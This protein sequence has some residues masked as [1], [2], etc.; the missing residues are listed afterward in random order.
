MRISLKN[1]A[2]VFANLEAYFLKYNQFY[3][4]KYV[5]IP[6]PGDV[7]NFIADSD[8]NGIPDTTSEVSLEGIR[9]GYTYVVVNDVLYHYY[10]DEN[11]KIKDVN[12][13]VRI[14]NELDNYIYNGMTK[15]YEE[16]TLEL[17]NTP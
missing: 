12:W 16:C 7:L 13:F 1:D 5:Y 9:Y 8:Q 4:G 6:V 11:D 17:N 10:V 15:M 14:G 3:G 2:S